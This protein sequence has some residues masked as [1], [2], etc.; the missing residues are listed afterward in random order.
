MKLLDLTLDS[1]PANVALD[2]ALLEAA[3]ASDGGEVLRLWEP[4]KPFVVIGRSSV[5]AAEVDLEFCRAHSIPVIR[6][7]SGGASIVTGRGCLM[8]AVVLEI[9]RRPELRMLDTTHRWILERVA[10]ALRSLR[11]DARPR[12]TSDLAVGDRKVSGNSLRR[13]RAWVLYHGTL[14]YGL[15][16]SLIERCLHVAPRQPAYRQGRSH[17][18]FVT[19]ISAAPSELKAA[20]TLAWDAREN[21]DDWPRGLTERLV[22]ERYALESW[23]FAR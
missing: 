7:A 4:E 2:E 23:N 22:K 1:P 6:R 9:S 15:S 16:A 13:N 17:S 19:T 5:A 21:L 3:A 10:D 12:G 11:I 18:D 8:Y 14:L 20:L